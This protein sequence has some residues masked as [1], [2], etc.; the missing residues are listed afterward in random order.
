MLK[1]SLLLLS[2]MCSTSLFAATDIVG[3]W[4]T[5]DDKTGDSR[6]DVRIVKNSDGTYSGKIFEIR[7]IA[8]KPLEPNCKNCKG[9]L[10]NKPYVGM[11]IFW[12]F[13]QDP[14]NPNEYKNGQVLDPLSGNVY[15]SKVKVNDKGTRLTVRGYI[16]V[17]MLGRSATWIRLPD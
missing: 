11:Q 1:K 3:K 16:G 14:K 17:S 7:P 6:A 8:D 2:L 9:D 5:V 12:N 13:K 4:R 10:K 15:Q